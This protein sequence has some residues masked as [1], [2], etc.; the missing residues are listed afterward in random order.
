MIRFLPFLAFAV[1]SLPAL[2]QT[3]YK[4]SAD[5]KLSYSD[6]PCAHGK[7]VALPAPAAGVAPPE[8]NAVTTQDSRT[9]LELEKLR[10]AQQKERNKELDRQAAREAR[11]QQKL[12]RAEHARRKTCDKLRLRHKW[13]QEDLARAGSQ[14]REAARVKVRRHAEA[15]AV[16]CP[17]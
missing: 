10:I 6:R 15:L 7:S 14:A 1:L 16:E 5:G 4:C 11:E 3:V 2:A 17:A 12:A 8:A 9:L 13:A